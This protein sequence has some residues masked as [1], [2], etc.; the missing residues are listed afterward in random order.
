M[1]SYF[2][3]Y[4][5]FLVLFFP[6]ENMPISAAYKCPLVCLIKSFIPHP[7]PQP[8]NLPQP[9]CYAIVSMSELHR[10]G[11]HCFVIFLFL[12]F[13]SSESGNQTGLCV[14][15]DLVSALHNGRARN[16]LQ[17]AT[18]PWAFYLWEQRS[19]SLVPITH[20]KRYS[21]NYNINRFLSSWF[22]QERERKQKFKME[23]TLSVSLFSLC[24]SFCRNE[25]NE[26]CS[27]E[28]RLHYWST[29]CKST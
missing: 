22:N 9:T 4:F 2:I 11:L 26:E 21:H 15:V 28:C 8:M 23:Q 18:L 1:L 6:K 3:L 16:Q 27:K 19:D 5:F 12:G 17:S 24:F 10:T 7:L 20:G 13:G 25:E 29:R 14:T